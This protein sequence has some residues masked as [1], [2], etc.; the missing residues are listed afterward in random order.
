MTSITSLISGIIKSKGPD[1]TE[2]KAVLAEE[3]EEYKLVDLIKLAHA[4]SLTILVLPGKEPLLESKAFEASRKVIDDI[5]KEGLNIGIVIAEG[6]LIVA[7]PMSGMEYI[8]NFKG[9]DKQSL[10]TEVVMPDLIIGVTGELI[11]IVRSI[12]IPSETKV[13]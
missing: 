2:L 10:S 3:L 8:Y 1:F 11:K 13:I 9:L 4:R 6:E 5:L 7:P 12:S